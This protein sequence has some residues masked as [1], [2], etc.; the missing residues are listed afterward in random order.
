MKKQ[1]IDYILTKM[2]DAYDNV[3]DLNITAGKPFQVESSGQLNSVEIDPPFKELT[4]FQIVQFLEDFRMMNQK[5]G[6]SKLISIKIPERM[7]AV[8][9]Q[10][11]RSQRIPY[12]TQIKHLMEQWINES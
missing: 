11:C 10:R 6:K 8:F 4:P 9:K 2:L 3:S 12:Q 7:L 1:E 5:P